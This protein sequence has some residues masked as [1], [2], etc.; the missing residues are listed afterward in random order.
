MTNTATQK[1]QIFQHVPIKKPVTF[2]Y[3]SD[4]AVPWRYATQKPD[5]GKHTSIIH[6]KD[7]LSFAKVSNIS[8]MSRMTHSGRIFVA[9]ELKG[10]AK[11][12]V[13]E[14]GKASPILDEVV[15]AGRF[16]KKEE[17]FNKKRNIC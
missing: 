5:G 17:D 16:A 4:K 13:E 11:A 6:A 2:P 9:P 7:D 10:K 1:P 8:G 12:G 14:S 3:K 15:P